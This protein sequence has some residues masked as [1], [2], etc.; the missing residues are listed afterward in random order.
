M[1]LILALK[2]ILVP[3]IIGG[4]TLAGRRWGPDVAGWLSAFPV[5]S[6][7]LLWFIAMEQGAPFAADASAATLSAVLAILV[8]GVSYAWAALRYSWTISLPFSLVCYLL[9]V[10]ALNAWAPSLMIA[11]PSVLLA[12]VLVPRIYPTPPDTEVST[13]SAARHDIWLR[14]LTGAALV[15][16]VTQFSAQLGSRLSGLFAMFP[17]IGL[18][19]TV[20]SHINA[21]AAFTIKQLRSM[22]FG[23][24]A[25]AAFCLVLALVLPYMNIAAAFSLALTATLAIQCLSRIYLRRAPVSVP[26]AAVLIEVPATTQK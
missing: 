18:V 5:V 12:L 6:A 8:F 22:V 16:L 14:M 23:Y 17:A 1:S 15:V 4:V 9:A 7:P 13:K 11:A 25:F 10:A 26:Q 20:F 19:L 3:S 21:G 24:Y 2:I